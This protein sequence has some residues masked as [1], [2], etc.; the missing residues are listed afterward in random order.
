MY[1]DVTQMPDEIINVMDRFE[2]IYH[3]AS[4]L[5]GGA[6]RDLI[7]GKPVADWDFFVDTLFGSVNGPNAMK[8]RAALVAEG[9]ER[10]SKTTDR[11]YP[12][13]QF[14][15]ETW[16]H[17]TAGGLPLQ[18][19]FSRWGGDETALLETFDIS[20]CQVALTTDGN[21]VHTPS[22]LEAY[23]YKYHRVFM[24][25]Y[26]VQRQLII[27]MTSHIPRLLAKYDWSVFMDYTGV[28]P[29]LLFGMTVDSKAVLEDADEEDYKLLWDSE[30]LDVDELL[31]EVDVFRSKP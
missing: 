18:L 4:C 21:V 16:H 24:R 9:Y 29:E 26:R 5:A 6:P 7:F 27:G 10:V 12:S 14:L 20:T 23:R 30:T 1:P 13:S 17:K 15:V 25:N 3:G 2:K 31:P 22:F 19:I 28:T 8:Y 11:E